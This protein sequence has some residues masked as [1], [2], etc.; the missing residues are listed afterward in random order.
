MYFSNYYSQVSVGTSS[1]SEFTINTSLMPAKVGVAFVSYFDREY[2]TIPKLFKSLGYYNMS[3][4]A[5]KG[6]FWNRNSMYKSLGYDKFYDQKAFKIDETIGLGLSDKSFFRQL[7]PILKKENDNHKNFYAT[8][9]MLTNHTPFPDISSYSKDPLDLKMYVTENGE[10]KAYPYLEGTVLGR[11]LQSVHYA[12][13]ALGELMEHLNTNGLLENS[14]IMFYGDHDARLSSSEYKRFYNYDYKNDKTLD[15]SDP[16][17]KKYGYYEHELNR[18]VPFFFWSKNDNQKINKTITNVMGAYDI[19]PTLGNMFGF[20]NKYALGSDIFNTNND[21]TVIFPNGN[22]VT[23]KIYYNSQS[24]EAYD[25]EKKEVIAKEL[26]PKE[27]ITKRTK[28]TDQKLNVSNDILVY[29]LLKKVGLKTN[30]ELKVG[31]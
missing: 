13:E 6:D 22:Y 3:F 9:I 21:N 29:N 18:S 19:L 28:E 12:D 24:D 31:K 15:E 17:Y 26:E 2:V 5:N 25:I 10:T 27:Y 14:V 23:N 16:N 11:Y 20:Y 1:D 8:L 4:H 7:T 30:D